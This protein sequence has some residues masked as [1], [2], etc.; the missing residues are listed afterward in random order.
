MN[1]GNYNN[2]TVEETTFT[3][4]E[5]KIGVISG[6]LNQLRPQTHTKYTLM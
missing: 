5:D 4:L 2:T 3:D 1:I 6:L